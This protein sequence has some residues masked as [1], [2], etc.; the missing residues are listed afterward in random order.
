MCVWF[1]FPSANRQMEERRELED[2]LVG[3]CI[4][5]GMCGDK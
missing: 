4:I 3:K 2:V 1:V 5:T